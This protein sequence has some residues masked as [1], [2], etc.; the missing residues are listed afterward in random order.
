[1]SI[2]YVYDSKYESSYEEEIEE[3]YDIFR[4]IL[5][6]DNQSHMIEFEIAKRLIKN[7]HI[8]IVKIYKIFKFNDICYIDMEKLDDNYI[9]LTKT[10]CNLRLALNHLHKQGIVYIDIKSDNIG[11][12]IDGQYKLFDFDNCGIVNDKNPRQ[13]DL[14]P[15]NKCVIYN[16]IKNYED[17]ILDFY[18]LDFIILKMIYNL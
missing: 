7:P 14:K 15:C 17:F 1:M 2:L 9:S 10:I 3:D 13:W 11:K 12:S 4:K 6:I 8:N 5:D 18:E 16:K